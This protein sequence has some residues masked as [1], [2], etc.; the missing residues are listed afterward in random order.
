[1]YDPLIVDTFIQL[2]TSGAHGSLVSPSPSSTFHALAS[3]PTTLTAAQ[4]AVLNSKTTA[5]ERLD[6]IAASTEETLVL[7]DLASGLAG[8]VDLG[9]VGD[10]IAKHLRRIIPASVIV[11]YVYESQSDHLVS[12]HSV[13]HHSSHLLGLRIPRGERLSGWVA[14]NRQT[15]VNAD[16]ILDLGEVARTLRPRLRSCV[17]TPL[18]SG[19]ELVGVLSLYSVDAD[20]FNEEHKRLLE[21]IGGQV[22]HSVR[23]ALRFEQHRATDLRDAGTGLPNI[24]HLERNSVRPM[25]RRPTW[26]PNA[27]ESHSQHICPRFTKTVGL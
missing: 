16:P 19:N 22:S 12:M 6:E 7:Y 15:I 3:D 11:F 8:H 17:S 26:S 4:G 2:H 27:L 25:L 9:D 24:R 1:M 23:H 13:G 21:V 5:A 14:A 18:V 10:V 20:A